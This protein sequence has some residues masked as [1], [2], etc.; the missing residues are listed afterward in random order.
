[1]IAGL[2][3]LLIGVVCG[4]R[5]FTG[6]AAVS[7][8]ARLGWLHLTGTALGFLAAPVTPYVVT[9]VAISELVYDKLPQSPSRKAPPGF[10]ARIASGGLCGAALA[11]GGDGGWLVG[12]SAGAAG[13][14]AGTLGGYELRARLVRMTGGR[15]WPIALLEDACAIGGAFAIVRWG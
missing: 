11:L 2:L 8:A 6:P 13:A 7:W 12:L 1:M 10:A 15:D 9:L 5:T 3:A 4:S 14:V